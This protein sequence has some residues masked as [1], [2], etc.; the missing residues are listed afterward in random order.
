MCR[1]RPSDYWLVR[2]GGRPCA[3]LALPP[4]VEA[5]EG[6]FG[7]VEW[8]GHPGDVIAALAALAPKLGLRRISWRPH[9]HESN[10]RRELESAGARLD[11][12]EP[13]RVMVRIVDFEGLMKAL[14]G[15]VREILGERVADGLSF[16]SAD[17][18]T[19]IIH[20]GDQELKVQGYGPLVELLFGTGL[21][22]L[23]GG[24][25]AGPLREP[26]EALLPLPLAQYDMTYA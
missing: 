13:G 15:Y 11:D 12:S 2:R 3:Y 19:F 7:L 10:V 16:R 14:A 26:L 4:S 8:G 25:G 20:L 18:E 21:A 22:G 9:P 17:E 24:I 1:N 6:T 23:E 5:S